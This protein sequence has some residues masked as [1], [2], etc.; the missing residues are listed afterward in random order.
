MTATAFFFQNR[1][2]QQEIYRR[3]EDIPAQ[4]CWIDIEAPTEEEMEML[5]ALPDLHPL[6]IEDALEQILQPKVEF[7]PGY[8]FLILHEYS[9]AS[10]SL[11]TEECDIFVHPSFLVTFHHRPL[12][13]INEVRRTLP[14]FSEDQFHPL[15]LFHSL[16]EAFVKSSLPVLEQLEDVV[17]NIEENVLKIKGND[18]VGEIIRL[19]K[20]LSALRKNLVQENEVL[21]SLF[22]TTHPQIPADYR[23]YFRDVY[24]HSYRVLLEVDS[25][26]DSLNNVMEVYASMLSN[27]LNTSMKIL[28]GIATIILPMTLITGIYGMNFEVMPELRWKWGY[29]VTLALI[30][31]IG[32]I[33]YSYLKKKM[34]L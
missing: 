1:S 7:F 30:L 31:G 14:S 17:E 8:I 3:R 19:R 4:F 9:V 20:I 11:Q 26:R 5:R 23:A 10:E 12:S 25:L 22:T 6:S 18:P 2:F 33:F 15:L 24:D 34:V 27:R 29:P 16:L 28:T 32:L 13:S 21:H